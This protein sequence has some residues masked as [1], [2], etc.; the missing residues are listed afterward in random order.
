MSGNTNIPNER[1]TLKERANLMGLAFK[2]NIPTA[3]LRTLVNQE[4]KPELKADVPEV[5]P[6]T[7]KAVMSQA[8]FEQKQ[9]LAKRRQMSRLRRVIISCNDPQMKDWDTTPYMHISNALISLPKMVVPLNV[10]W[11]VPQ[12]YYDFLKLQKCGIPVKARDEKGRP[13]TKRKEIKKYNIQ[14]LD[15]LTNDE[16]D[17]L[18]AAQISRDG[19]K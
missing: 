9:L 17:E 19:V 10:E 3:K 15:D 4:I 13:I 16:L 6:A 14:D 8:Q 12:A 2:D 18:K 1:D 11:H 5:T 7:D